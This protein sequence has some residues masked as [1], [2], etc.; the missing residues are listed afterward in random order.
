MAEFLPGILAIILEQADVL[1]ARIALEVEDALGDQAEEVCDLIVAGI[2]QVAVVARIFDQNLVRAD[3]VHAVINTVA[4]AAGFALN[5]VKRRGVNHGTRGPGDAGRVGRFRDHL[6][7]RR[8]AVVK[9]A[10][11]YRETTGS[12]RIN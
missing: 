2:P 6:H 4:A 9:T 10:D 1:D 7:R 3:R 5:A 11:R 8:G 12:R